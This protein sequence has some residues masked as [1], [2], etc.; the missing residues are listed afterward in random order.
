MKIEEKLSFEEYWNDKRF[1]AK[2]CNLGSSIGRSGD[3]IYEPLANGEWK[4]HQSWHSYPEFSC[5]KCKAHE[6]NDL[7]G[8]FILISSKFI[9]YGREAR[10]L[11]IDLAKFILPVGRGYKCKYAHEKVEKWNCYMEDILTKQSGRLAFPTIW[12]DSIIEKTSCGSGV[13]SSTTCLP[14]PTQHKQTGRQCDIK[15][16]RC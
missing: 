5:N 8:L 11:P 12:D 6:Q 1:Q 10:P 3:N 15:K 7:G 9:Y 14:A 13:D 16:R 2:K 4:Q